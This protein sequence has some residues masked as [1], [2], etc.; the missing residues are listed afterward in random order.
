MPAPRSSSGRPKTSNSG[1]ARAKTSSPQ[2]SKTRTRPAPKTPSAT[3]ATRAGGTDGIASLVEQLVNRV[4]KPLDL[5]LLSRERI[6]ETLD[7]AAERGRVTRADANELVSELVK[8]GRQQTDDLLRD[9]E[10][11]L[12][13]GRGQ[14]GSATKESMERIVRRAD[15]A[16]R[17]LGGGPAL[18]IADYDELTAGQVELHLDG[19]KPAELRAVRDYERRHAN[20]KSVLG[21]I[22]R[23]LG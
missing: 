12:G 23:A 20:R 1:A 7:E 14:I 4:L 6:Q 18:P 10:R 15:R 3:R 11:L 19:L 21:A 5:V 9:L 2:R 17:T 13:R 22:E 16:R 8:R